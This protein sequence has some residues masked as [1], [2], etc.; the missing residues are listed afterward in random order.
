VIYACKDYHAWR[1]LRL[2]KKYLLHK[3]QRF[4]GDRLM[5]K[6]VSPIFFDHGNDRRKRFRGS[7]REICSDLLQ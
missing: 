7:S 3:L 6:L 4:V 1:L 2:Q 5:I